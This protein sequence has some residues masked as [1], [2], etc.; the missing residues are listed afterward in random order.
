MGIAQA[1]SPAAKMRFAKVTNNVDIKVV[2][3]YQSKINL[4]YIRYE[5]HLFVLSLSDTRAFSV[6]PRQNITDSGVANCDR[7]WYDAQDQGVC[8]DYCRWVGNCG[9][10]GSC[11][12]WSC[13]L[14]GTDAQYSPK[15]QYQEG[16]TRLKTC[17]DNGT[18]AIEI[19]C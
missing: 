4:T 16:S 13:A 2:Q 9:C 3:I 7:G 17:R 5:L 6:L 8:N 12:F 11:S 1:T 10:R 14:A 18:S 15:G 19:Y